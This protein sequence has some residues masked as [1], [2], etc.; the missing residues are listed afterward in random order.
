M[1]SQH[2]CSL[3]GQ[4]ADESRKENLHPILGVCLMSLWSAVAT[5]WERWREG[6]RGV[7]VGEGTWSDGKWL[8]TSQGGVC[9]V[10]LGVCVVA[11]CIGNT[12]YV[13]SFRNLSRQTRETWCRAVNTPKHTLTKALW[14]ESSIMK[15][16]SGPNI[17]TILELELTAEDLESWSGVVMR[18]ILPLYSL[19]LNMFQHFARKK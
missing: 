19:K 11:V 4:A 16:N 1:T 5:W 10:E 14:L 13:W 2:C 12:M 18:E 9:A 8:A 7:G 3:W 6:G 17:Y 15:W